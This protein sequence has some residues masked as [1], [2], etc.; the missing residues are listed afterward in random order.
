MPIASAIQLNG[1]ETLVGLSTH[2]EQLVAPTAPGG[3]YVHGPEIQAVIQFTKKKVGSKNTWPDDS[4]AASSPS[5]V[6]VVSYD[7]LIE[8]SWVFRI[9]YEQH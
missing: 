6:S 5:R 1:R 8:V 7:R 2:E 4:L 9:C 3:L